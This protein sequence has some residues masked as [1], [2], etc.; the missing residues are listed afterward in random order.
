[1]KKSEFYLICIISTRCFKKTLN[2]THINKYSHQ[3][4]YRI[5]AIKFAC[6]RK[7]YQRLTR[8]RNNTENLTIS[9]KY[10]FD[11]QKCASIWDRCFTY[12]KSVS[13]KKYIQVICVIMYCLLI[14]FSCA[15]LVSTE[16][17]EELFSLGINF[18]SVLKIFLC[19]LLDFITII[20]ILYSIAKSLALYS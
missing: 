18:L 14:L 7:A 5:V 1:M 20:Q 3:C 12:K 10:V 19:R 15:V 2:D 16:S 6:P 17:V 9:N 8:G 13:E 11:Y 4:S